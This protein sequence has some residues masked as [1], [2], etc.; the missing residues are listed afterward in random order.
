METAFRGAMDCSIP[1]VSLGNRGLLSLPPN[2]LNFISRKKAL[3][4]TLQRTGDPGRKAILR[5]D[6]RNL[7]NIIQGAI[8]VFEESY[9]TDYLQGVQLGDRTFRQVKRAAG[10]SKNTPVTELVDDLGSFVTD[11]SENADLLADRFLEVHSGNTG[12]RTASF[13]DVVRQE[14]S[15]LEDR[16]PLLT[17]GEVMMAD[18]TGADRNLRTDQY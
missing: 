11:D 15:A 4:R 17:F 14:V 9:W 7:D 13:E 10:L 8:A 3:R 2:I 18:G 12:L 16:M 6:I 5:A 1:K